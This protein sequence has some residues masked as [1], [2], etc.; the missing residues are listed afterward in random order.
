[1]PGFP[2]RIGKYEILAEL[3]RGAMGTVYKA[4]DPRLDRLVAV[5]MMSEELLIEE[6]MR[7]RFQR[8]AKSAANLQ[9]PNITVE[10]MRRGMSPT[11]ACL[12]T[13]KRVVAMTPPRLLEADGRTPKFQLN[14]YAVNKRGEYGAA[15]LFPSRYAVHDGSQAS[16]KDTASLFQRRRG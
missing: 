15:A 8:E 5:K 2:S 1:M 7:G 14:F 12:E 4:R 16:F 10:H 6:E 11:D 9:H 3:G 13:L